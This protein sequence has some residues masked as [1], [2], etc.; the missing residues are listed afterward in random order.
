MTSV[1]DN[2]L[3]RLLL[4]ASAPG[5][6]PNPSQKGWYGDLVVV[7]RWDQFLQ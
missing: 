4:R 3:P 6:R 7:T 5:V 1:H 2:E